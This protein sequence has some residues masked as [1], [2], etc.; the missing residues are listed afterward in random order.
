MM[1]ARSRATGPRHLPPDET[2][3]ELSV[4][5]IFG[6]QVLGVLDVQSDK[7]NAFGEE[8]RILFAALAEH[9]A[10]AMRNAYLYRSETWRRQVADSLREVAGLLSAD[11]DLDQVLEAIL[12]ELERTLPTG[13]GCHLV[14]ERIVQRR[15]F[16]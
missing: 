15:G 4:P 11:L 1:S 12:A 2:L 10:I 16:G 14:I 3:S 6:G 5:L 9:I 7:L 8:D 13:C